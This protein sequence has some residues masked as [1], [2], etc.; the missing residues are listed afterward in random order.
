MKT[1]ISLRLVKLTRA[2]AKVKKFLYQFLS[3]FSRESFFGFRKKYLAPIT[4][5]K[6]DSKVEAIY[7]LIVAFNTAPNNLCLFTEMSQKEVFFFYIIFKI[8]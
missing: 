8:C 1:K 4:E 5:S 6:M 2:K 7:L 3:E